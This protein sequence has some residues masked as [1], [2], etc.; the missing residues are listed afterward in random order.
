MANSIFNRPASWFIGLIG[1][2]P[3]QGALSSLYAATSLG[4]TLEAN[5][6]D[7]YGPKATKAVPSALARDRALGTRLWEWTEAELAR[8]GFA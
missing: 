7:Y 5:N 1:L 3:D 6:G 4:L 8:L 2:T